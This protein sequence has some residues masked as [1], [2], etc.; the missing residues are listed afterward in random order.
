[1][2]SILIR[3]AGV[4]GLVIALG[5]VG[6]ALL[7]PDDQF[8]LLRS[9]FSADLISKIESGTIRLEGGDGSSVQSAVKIV[10]AATEQENIAAEHFFLSKMFGR[11]GIEWA[12]TGQSGLKH[13]G[14]SYDVVRIVL[15]GEKARRDYYF[16]ITEFRQN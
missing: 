4:A 1:M 13:A 6:C 11:Q 12:P 7:E 5:L 15:A 10:G 16:D 2:K 3:L 8:T 14:R 9:R